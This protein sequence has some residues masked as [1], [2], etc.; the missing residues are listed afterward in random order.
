MGKCKFYP[1][2]TLRT[3]GQTGINEHLPPNL[4]PQTLSECE[5]TM[6]FYASLLPTASFLYQT[7]Y[8]L[9]GKKTMNLARLCKEKVAIS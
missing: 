9:P 1:L 5:Y 8:E 3:I 2:F 6:R 4:C 7:G